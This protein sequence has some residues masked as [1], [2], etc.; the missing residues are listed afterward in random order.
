MNKLSYQTQLDFYL[1]IALNIAIL[2]KQYH[3]RLYS[4]TEYENLASILM[5]VTKSQ[6]C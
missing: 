1:F 4:Y 3:T 6:L 5:S 2:L